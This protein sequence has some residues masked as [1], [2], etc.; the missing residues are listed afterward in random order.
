MVYQCDI[1]FL[2]SLVR[3]CIFLYVQGPFLYFFFPVNYLLGSFSI[4][5]IVFGV[6][7]KIKF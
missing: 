2:S 5:S 3:L 4:Y 6:T 1:N 7:F